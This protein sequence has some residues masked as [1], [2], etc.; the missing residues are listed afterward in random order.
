M[1]A[2]LI[3]TCVGGRRA[4]VTQRIEALPP[5]ANVDTSCQPTKRELEVLDA[6]ID[7]G[8]CTLAA[9]R[10]GISVKTIEIHMQHLREKFDVLSNYQLIAAHVT[11]KQRTGGFE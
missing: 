5:R 7:T 4:G 11:S 3:S 2:A 9:V 10:L 1:S 6:V 8:Y